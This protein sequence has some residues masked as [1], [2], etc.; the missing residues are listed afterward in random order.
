MA[1]ANG[2]VVKRTPSGIPYQ[3]YPNGSVRV[4]LRDL[5]HLMPTLAFFHPM[6]DRPY[7]HGQWN[8]RAIETLKDEIAKVFAEIKSQSGEQHE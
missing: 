4:E 3:R 2:Y 6:S 7:L 8:K 1:D 5:I